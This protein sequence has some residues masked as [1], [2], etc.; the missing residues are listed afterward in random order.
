V[1]AALD[2]T[3]PQVRPSG[4]GVITGS[5][6]MRSTGAPVEGIQVSARLAPSNPYEGE[7]RK[8]LPESADLSPEA[9]LRT[10]LQRMVESENKWNAVTWTSA[11]GPDGTFAIPGLPDGEYTV[12]VTHVRYTLSERG[13][14]QRYPQYYDPN[15]L[16]SG[17]ASISNVVPGGDAHFVAEALRMVFVEVLNPDSTPAAPLQL[18][19]A[20]WPKGQEGASIEDVKTVLQFNSNQ[21]WRGMGDYILLGE[22]IHGLRAALLPVHGMVKA[23]PVRVDVEAEGPDPR[24]V[25]QLTPCAGV[26][27]SIINEAGDLISDSSYYVNVVE[28]KSGEPKP[29]ELMRYQ[30]RLMVSP[31]KIRLGTAVMVFRDLEPGAYYAVVHQHN[32]IID[33]K[34][35]SVSTELVE[36]SVAIKPPPRSDYVVVTVLGPDGQP[37]EDVTLSSRLKHKG[38][39]TGSSQSTRL[40]DGTYMVFHAGAGQDRKYEEPVYSVRVNSR[41]FGQAEVEYDLGNA[42]VANV[43]L[44]A[45]A[46]LKV[47]IN[48]ARGHAAADKLRVNLAGQENAMLRGDYFGDY[49]GF[50]GYP[51]YVY[52]G[53]TNKGVAGEFTFGPMQPGEVTAILTISM[54]G[55][56]WGGMELARESVTLAPGQNEIRIQL[57]TLFTITVHAPDSKDGDNVTLRAVNEGGNRSYAY[58]NHSVKLG[59]DLRCLF[60]H[61]PAGTY[62]ISGRTSGG[63]A[64]ERIQLPG[65]STVTLAAPAPKPR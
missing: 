35:L 56:N 5:V 59:S 57:P 25:I 33:S 53:T 14:T 8:P 50:D 1:A 64:S 22:G 39:T 32:R 21:A 36:A 4:D 3:K 60:E 16:V 54:S 52:G 41:D 30:G 44:S 47:I 19:T 17:R 29:T 18:S 15:S 49:P 63:H 34:P 31:V 48:G 27:L 40:P 2:H 24:V 46:M 13:S 9:Q 51:S 38:G 42:P 58:S 61:V 7:I 37:T 28:A 10:R 65:P 62:T 20:Q 26:S 12:T 6:M 55:S 11:T 45:P 23:D 43:K